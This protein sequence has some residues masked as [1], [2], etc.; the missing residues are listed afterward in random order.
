MTEV[1]SHCRKVGMEQEDTTRLRETLRGFAESIM[2]MKVDADACRDVV[3]GHRSLN[4]SSLQ[5]KEQCQD[6]VV[7]GSLYRLA[8]VNQPSLQPASQ[9]YLINGR[10]VGRS[11]AASSP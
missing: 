1:V 6:S 10:L 4:L 7:L 5:T 2:L 9:T 8:Q 3:S 11:T